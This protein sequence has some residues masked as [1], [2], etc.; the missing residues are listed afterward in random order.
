MNN[1]ELTWQDVPFKGFEV[2]LP[3][4]IKKPSVPTE[5][6]EEQPASASSE[7]AASLCTF[8]QV[9]PDP[10]ARRIRCCAGS[11]RYEHGA[12]GQGD[13]GAA[14]QGIVLEDPPGLWQAGDALGVDVSV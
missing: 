3:L 1:N 11:G 14:A 5:E 6:P 12:D 4:V 8:T 9:R 2:L 7:G 13:D 10:H